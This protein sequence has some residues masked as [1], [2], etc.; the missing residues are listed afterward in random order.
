MPIRPLK[1]PRKYAGDPPGPFSTGGRP[2]RILLDLP[3]SSRVAD[4]VALD[5]MTVPDPDHMLWSICQREDIEAFW[6]AGEGEREPGAIHLG[7]IDV[8]NDNRPFTLIRENGAWMRAISRYRQLEQLAGSAGPHAVEI[9]TK[10]ALADELRVDLI[11]TSNEELL[12]L[13]GGYARQVNSMTISDALAI[14]GL[15]M[16][17]GEDYEQREGK[18]KFRIAF[19]M[20]AWSAVR[21]QIPAGW[22]WAGAL[23]DHDSVEHDDAALIFEALFERLTRALT[24]R[25]VLH[26][27]VSE[28]AGHRSRQ[29]M[30]E[31]FDYIMLNLVGAFD[32]TARSAHLGAGLPREKRYYAKWQTDWR[33][34]IGVPHL[35]AMFDEE[36]PAADLFAVLRM[37]RNTV[38]GAGLGSLVTR[39]A[40]RDD[41]VLAILPRDDADDIVARLNRLDP[42]EDWGIGATTSIGS[43]F[44]AARMTESLLPRVLVTL[45]E[46]VELCPRSALKTAGRVL[47]TTPGDQFPFDLG[48]STRANLLYGLP[49][50]AQ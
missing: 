11:A 26:R 33:K 1:K 43:H 12:A 19:D 37:L 16:R 49:L 34:R 5:K 35:A 17:A 7:E 6:L 42:N 27:V 38:H 13:P 23:V 50:P 2:L 40:G 25:D 4:R 30:V 39:H 41:E 10:V 32:A 28:P 14:V 29:Q 9:L 8:H 46:A 31:A 24:Q 36:Q 47:T 48:T 18:L 22:T 45:N 15:Y 20:L 3:A 21:S 44:N